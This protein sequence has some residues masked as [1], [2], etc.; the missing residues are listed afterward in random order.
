MLLQPIYCT[1]IIVGVKSKEKFNWFVTDKKLWYLDYTKLYKSLEN[2]YT[3]MGRSNKR[4]L[5]EV[6]DFASF[7][8][9]RWGIST[10][11]NKTV[12]KFLA[13][14]ESYSADAEEL[15][16]LFKS[17]PNDTTFYPALLVDFDKKVFYSYFP[18]PE[19]FQAFVPDD[20]YGTYEKFDLLIPDEYR[21][22]K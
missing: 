15:S 3:Q 9:K 14:I 18:E 22:W 1:N 6:G 5:Y 4:F 12:S 21:Y 20:W 13:M 10:I 16:V 17:N 11:N 7:C 8:Q 19:N 2:M